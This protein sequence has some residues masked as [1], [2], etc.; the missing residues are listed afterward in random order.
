MKKIV[1]FDIDGT[2]L[3]VESSLARSIFIDAFGEMFSMDIS[4]SIPSFHGKTDLQIIADISNLYGID[5]SNEIEQIW[6]NIFDK[7]EQRIS[8]ESI[9]IL[10]GAAELIEEIEKANNFELGLVTGNFRKNAYLKLSLVGLDKYFPFGG[11]GDDCPDRNKLPLIAIER[12]KKSKI[13][14][15]AYPISNSVIIGDTF[16]DIQA[17]KSN[18]LKA[19]AV[20]TGKAPL[21]ELSCYTPY[22]LFEDLS[23]YKK[24]FD[25]LNKL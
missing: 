6:N 1:L 21:S 17:A 12:A 16:R 23:D 7:F 22:V 9:T 20:A 10:P 13:I 3:N 4:K 25:C 19:V 18:S 24:V 11:F 5:Y 2:I 14:D 8:K 15:D